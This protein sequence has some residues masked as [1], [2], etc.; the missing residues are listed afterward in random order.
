MHLLASL[1]AAQALL[2]HLSCL[3][4]TCQIH[5]HAHMAPGVERLVQ[6]AA[7]HMLII[8]HVLTHHPLSRPS[9]KTRV[10][11]AVVILLHMLLMM[12]GLLF[13]LL[14][15]WGQTR[16]LLGGIEVWS[17]S[18]RLL[19]QKADMRLGWR[20]HWP[21]IASTSACAAVCVKCWMRTA[22][23]CTANCQQRRSMVVHLSIITY[24]L[25]PALWQNLMELS[26]LESAALSFESARLACF[27]CIRLHEGR[28]L[29]DSKS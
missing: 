2:C 20:E 6:I 21:A 23:A 17:R 15:A 3:P 14:Q 10:C 9:A 13:C 7:T 8:L 4:Y 11:A 1:Q 12:Q 19:C 24:I 5:A 25:C 28:R 16:G 29:T 22:L 18:H 26:L 27:A